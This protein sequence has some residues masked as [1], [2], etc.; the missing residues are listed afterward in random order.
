[1]KPTDAYYFDVVLIQSKAYSYLTLTLILTLID[2]NRRFLNMQIFVKHLV[3]LS[4][5]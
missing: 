1:M 2:S 3:F 5:D 4:S